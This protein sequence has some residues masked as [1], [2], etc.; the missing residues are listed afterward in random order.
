METKREKILDTYSGLTFKNRKD[1]VVELET[2][3]TPQEI[4]ANKRS[5]PGLMINRGCCYAGC[6][7]VVLGPIQDA[8]TLEHGPIGCGYYTWMTRRNKARGINGKSL[9]QYSFSTD[10]Q[11]TDIVFGGVKKL[12]QAVKEAVEIFHPKAVFICATCPV[13]LIGDDINSVA[14]W[15]KEEFDVQ[16]ISFSCEG[17]KGVSQSAGHHIA[18]NGLMKDV[19]G[20]GTNKPTTPFSINLLGEYNIG[21]DAFET[22][23]ILTK[24][25]YQVV[26]KFT[27][28]GVY[29]E[30]SS[31]HLANLNLVQCHRSIN[32]IAEMMKVKYGI[33]WLKVNFIGIKETIRT[34]REMAAYFDDEGLKKRTEEVIAEELTQIQG[35]WDYYKKKLSGKKAG[36]F[37]GGSRSHHYMD[38]LA[39]FGVETVV[40]GYE[41]AHRDDYEGREVIPDI[42]LDAD[43][44]NI[45]QLSP[46]KDESMYR[47]YIDDDTYNELKGKIELDYYKGMMKDMKKGSLI[48]DDY[49]EAETED[50]LSLYKPDIFY[51]GIKD[52]FMI[53]K[54]GTPAKQMHSYDYDGPYTCFKGAINFAHDTFDEVNAPA[55]K[56]LTPPWNTEPTLEGSLGNSAIER[57]EQ[58]A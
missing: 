37:V 53:L 5:V 3:H 30:I 46:E 14:K 8:V 27:G 18:N 4:T 55:W 45:E 16:C 56:L 57:G 32:Y 41:F 10:L 38:L 13:G 49:N 52:N 40:T 25:G 44:K 22:E 9:I 34:L 20:T 36:I 2:N 23:R 6:K 21:G 12:K 58:H 29:D 15:A 31:A 54:S 28:D 47:R 48:I 7:G 42:K 51:S 39:D 50:A 26:S 17:Y 24:I 35:D 11:E 33:D 43:T 19:I 1:H